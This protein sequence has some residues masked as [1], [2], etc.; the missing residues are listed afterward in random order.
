[1]SYEAID[2]TRY[3]KY[4]RIRFT[5]ALPTPEICAVTLAYEGDR[6]DFIVRAPNTKYVH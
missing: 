2:C 3:H 6:M 5:L 4:D 1:M